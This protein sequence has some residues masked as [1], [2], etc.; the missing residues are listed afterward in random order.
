MNSKSPS[1]K[2]AIFS[3]SLY[4]FANTI[5]SM[6]V[7]SLYFALWVTSDHAGS[8]ILYSLALSLSMLAVALSAPL[9]GVFSDH[10]GNRRGPLIAF[11]LL[12]VL[13]TGGIGMTDQ[14]G[15]GLVLFVIANYG[16][17][18]ALVFYNGM[19]PGLASG[20]RMG[21]VSG[22][23]VS[24]GYVGAI[25]GLLLVKPFVEA[26]GR[27]SAFIPTAVLFLVF[28]IPCFL[29]VPDSARKN[30]EPVS[31]QKIWRTALQTGRDI[32]RYRILFKFLLIHF[33]ILDVVNTL[34]AFMAIYAN[35]VMGFNDSQ[36]NTFLILSTVGAMLGSLA[37]GGLARWK[38]A[39]KTYL[40]V[41]WIWI[42][43]LALAVF[44]P[45]Q[46][47]FWC[48]GPLAGM[49][50]GGV[51]TVSRALL[52]EWSPAEKLGEFFGFYG[53][54][55]KIAAIMGP[56]LWGSVVWVLNDFPILKYRGAVFA[57]LL[58]A[59]GTLFLYRSLM[60][61]VGGIRA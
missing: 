27:S 59:I 45:D 57:L 50:M 23:G 48:V 46:T 16:Y 3:W 35:K 51:W 52:A 17:H 13:A 37:I 61:E 18:C 38:G 24:L 47:T 28:S 14:L 15:T 34:I 53:M 20:A 49:G 12:C 19:L 54:A 22:Y 43:V 8:D 9:Y 36:I 39:Q 60:K 56:L 25:A 42:I 10:T 44:S 4:D 2:L 5:F 40:L 30:P 6:N 32:Q 11:T 41:L 29:F 21:L 26:G 31:L 1:G 33:L 58:I 55:G 7:I